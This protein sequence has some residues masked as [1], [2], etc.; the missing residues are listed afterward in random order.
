MY[1]HGTAAPVH[2]NYDLVGHTLTRIAYGSDTMMNTLNKMVYIRKWVG[3]YLH[4]TTGTRHG[5]VN[6]L[7]KVVCTRWVW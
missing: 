1:V 3:D 7:T 4:Q 2:R 6:P 5:L